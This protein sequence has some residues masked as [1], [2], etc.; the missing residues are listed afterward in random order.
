MAKGRDTCA[1][2]GCTNE[3]S[4]QSILRARVKPGVHRIESILYYCD[5]HSE[6]PTVEKFISDRQGAA[7][8]N[9]WEAGNV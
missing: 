5:E 8:A 6:T 7:L 1:H 3:V 4:T 2:P 9:N